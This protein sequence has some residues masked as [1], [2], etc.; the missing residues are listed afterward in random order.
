MSRDSFERRIDKRHAVNAAEN[1]GNIADSMS[2][3]KQLMQRVQSGEITLLD[4][5]KELKKIKRNAKRDGKVT[6][7]QAWSR[8]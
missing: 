8:G 5:Q 3:R 2:V 4:A 1:A 6:R 7:Q